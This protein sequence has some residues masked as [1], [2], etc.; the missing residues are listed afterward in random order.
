MQHECYICARY[1]YIPI[2]LPS[3]LSALRI[4]TGT[5]PQAGT[6]RRLAVARRRFQKR[7]TLGPPDVNP[8]RPARETTA[9]FRAVAAGALVVSLG[10]G[11]LCAVL[12]SVVGY[13]PF[14]ALLPS[15]VNFILPL[16]IAPAILSC[17]GGADPSSASA[18]GLRMDPDSCTHHEC[19]E[20]VL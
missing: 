18:D 11:P 5:P 17:A 10:L 20:I 8:W 6:E 9:F 19:P 1:V 14:V 2:P 16:A 13:T 15:V 3:A 12:T 7:R 4:W